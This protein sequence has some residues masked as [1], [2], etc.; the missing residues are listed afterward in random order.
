MSYRKGSHSIFDLKYHVIWCTKYRYR[1][2]TGEVGERARELIREI[3]KANYV[4]IV[5]GSMSPDHVHLLV[6]V[7]PH[8][9]LSKLLQYLKGK[10]SRKLLMEFNHLQKRYWG[11]HLWARGY[12]AVTVGNLNEKQVQ[13][14]I[15]NQ[16]MHRQ[17]DNFSIS[18]H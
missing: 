11:Q 4:E 17:D 5:S 8:L 12:F 9:S 14:Y 10:S 13:E 6:S 2:L 16:E 7:P 15:E 1:I 18:A 3:C